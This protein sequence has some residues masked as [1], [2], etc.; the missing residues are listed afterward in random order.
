MG[1]KYSDICP[2]FRTVG[3][4]TIYCKNTVL[5]WNPA[6]NYN[7]KIKKRKEDH[8]GAALLV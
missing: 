4:M 6:K 2:K 1:R 7:N 5:N 3:W 8:E